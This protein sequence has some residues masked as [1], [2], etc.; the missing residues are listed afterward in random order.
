MPSPQQ[1]VTLAP[2]QIQELERRLSDLRHNINNNLSL[3]VAAI[4]LLRR[5]PDLAMRM[6][7]TIS[8]QP[9]KILD[10][11]KQFSDQLERALHIVREPK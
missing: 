3:I 1:S 2:E 8:E 5:K 10:E 6:V 9:S 7:E 11:V 4:E